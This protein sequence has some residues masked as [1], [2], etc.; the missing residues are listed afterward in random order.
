MITILLTSES[1][2]GQP[3]QISDLGLTP[4][5][6]SVSVGWEGPETLPEG[7]G[8]H[9]QVALDGSPVNTTYSMVS[10]VV[11]EGLRP[12][13]SYVVSVSVKSGVTIEEHSGDGSGEAQIT[14]DE[15]QSER[16]SNILSEAFSTILPAPA[17]LSLRLLSAEREYW[18]FNVPPDAPDSARY[19]YEMWEGSRRAYSHTTSSVV[20]GR[21]SGSSRVFKS[22]QVTFKAATRITDS[23]GNE[24]ISEY[25]TETITVP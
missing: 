2:T 8:Y 7:Y 23:E 9:V 17:N 16:T 6:D 11:V 25:V 5:L 18:S 24:R 1:F 21:V 3:V 19:R 20:D 13:L 22:G 15:D 14:V 10:P 4:G 12:G